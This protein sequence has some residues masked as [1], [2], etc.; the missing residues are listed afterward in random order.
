[1][2]KIIIIALFSLSISSLFSQDTITVMQY[3]LLNYGNYTSYCTTDNNDV[4]MKDPFIRTII[5][6]IQ[7]D[8]FS[9]N[10]ISKSVDMQQRMLD[11]NLNIN[12]IGYY[13][14]ANPINLANSYLV[15]QLYYNSQKLVLQSHTIAQSYI[16]DI[17]V[18]KLYYRSDDLQEGDTATIVC[19]VAHLKAGNSSEE[20]RR[21]MVSNAMTYLDETDNDA[22][23][24][25]MG[26]FNTYTSD[27]DCYQLLLNNPNTDVVFRDPIDTPGDW[28]ND[29]NYRY[30]HT[31]STHASQ[32][33]CA[34][35]GGM[36]DRFD[37]ILAND[38]VLV[39]EKDVRYIANSYR[40]VGQ[41]GE[42][43]NK[44]VNDAPENQSA[45]TEV[46]DALFGNSDHLPIVVKLRVD[47]TLDIHE[48]NLT[49]FDDVIYNNP[50]SDNWNITISTLMNTTVS[51]DILNTRG[52]IVFSDK[53][54][55]VVGNNT[56]NY[57]LKILPSG[58]YMA[59]FTDENCKKV[60][61]KF[62]KR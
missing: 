42:H 7:P 38:N 29:Y 10:E 24:L 37:F 60:I 4:E 58:F 27:E 33:G 20:K 5:D 57:N 40:A 53:Q 54:K 22:N 39:G 35:H 61:K 16:R 18:Y 51:I 30:V 15:N 56:I 43:F 52:I 46:V 45:P 9:V 13:R 17:D 11:N 49:V 47:K 19:V 8:I 25:F 32:N 44:S 31:Q 2:K 3:N 21:V 14:M 23:Y 12:G 55:I 59:V 6:Y 26:D 36:D 62:V 34:S 48:N 28:N 41:D 1:M 50:A